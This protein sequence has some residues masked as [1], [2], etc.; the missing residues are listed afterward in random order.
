MKEPENP[1]ARPPHRIAVDAVRISLQDRGRTRM[2]AVTAFLGALLMATIGVPAAEPVA[3]DELIHS[4]ETTFDAIP[5]Q[6]MDHTRTT[7]TTGEFV[8]TPAASAVSRS[9]LFSG[10]PVPVVARFSMEKA[11]LSGRSTLELA[12][13]FRLPDGSRQHMV[14]LNT[15]V[16]VTPDPATFKEMIAATKPDSSTGEPDWSRLRDFLT[17]HPDAFAS[18]RLLSAANS[19]SS[20]ATSSYFSIHTF[21][22]INALGRTHFVRWRFIPHDREEQMR[23]T[24]VSAAANLMEERLTSRLARGEMRWDMIVYLGQPGDTTD[25]AAIA[26]PEARAHFKAGTLTI[27]QTVPGD[28]CEEATFDPLIVAD[29]IAPTDDPVLLFR[30]PVYANTFVRQLSRALTAERADSFAHR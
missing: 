10:A 23:T 16:F 1:L 18:S 28:Y 4:F 13:E 2:L 11:S 3:P 12:L 21:R 19:L 14:M 17:L 9:R 22:F 24:E 29:G 8:G 15:P 6:H 7:C 20:H 25:N 30:S 5:G 26:W 27:A